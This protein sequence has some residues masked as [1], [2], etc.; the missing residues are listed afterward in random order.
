MSTIHIVPITLLAL[1]SIGAG[2]LTTP[3]PPPPVTANAAWTPVEAEFDGIPMQLVPPGC[4][5]MGSSDADPNE[6]PIS[7]VCF[8]A[9]FW[10]DQTE[11]TQGD[12]ERLGGIK[13]NANGFPAPRRPVERVTWIEARD[14]CAGRGGR[15]PTEAEW[16]YAARGPD[17]LSYPWGNAWDD[18][19]VVWNRTPEQGTASVGRYPSGASWVGALDLSGNVWEWTASRYAPY[20]YDA[21]DGRNLDGQDAESLVIRGGHW[22]YA[23]TGFLRAAHRS[24]AAPATYGNWLGF[25]CVRDAG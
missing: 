17:S 24:D 23:V 25:R 16:E 7:E 6:L 12:F 11:V 3:T 22:D 14:F 19:A 2:P 10:I 5:M 9:A 8:D 15:L 21:D 18:G 13:A 20:P 4:F 1:C